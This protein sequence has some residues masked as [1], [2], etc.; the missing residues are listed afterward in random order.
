MH[1]SSE[2]AQGDVREQIR[3]GV[4]AVIDESLQLGGKAQAFGES[5]ELL[6]VLPE[7]DSMAVLTILTGLEEH[8]GI[9]VDDDDVSADTFE[10]VGTL[11]DLVQ[12][13]SA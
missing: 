4:V 6:G 13:K 3:A 9:V 1:N 11:I 5:T 2:V 7:L 12:E 8:F 10:T